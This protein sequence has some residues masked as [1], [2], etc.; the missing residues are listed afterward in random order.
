MSL[1]ARFPLKS[2]NKYQTCNEGS[3][4]MLAN[5]PQPEV[6][7]VEPEE[8][9]QKALNPCVYDLSSMT[10]D[11]SEHSEGK[12]V[13]SNDS[14]RTNGS[15]TSSTDESNFKLSE[16]TQKHTR[17]DHCPLEN[18]PVGAT[19]G[20]AQE[21]SCIGSV[22]KELSD[23]V[24]SQCS[25]VT[26]QICADCSVEQS[27]EKI[28][29]CSESNSEVEELSSAAKYNIFHDRTSFSKL[30]EMASSTTLHEVNSQI[31]KSTENSR[32]ASGQSIGIKHGDASGQSIGIKHGNQIEKLNVTQDSP[33]ASI[34]KCNAYSL[35]MTPN[36][37]VL[38]VG[39]FEIEDPSTDFRKNKD[40]NGIKGPS[41]QAPESET[42]AA[43]ARS[44]S[45][46]SQFH[47]QQQS[48][49]TEQKALPV[50]GE[51]QNPIQ[52]ARESDSGH[53]SNVINE[54][55]KIGSTKSTKSRVHLKEKK[56]TFDWDSLRRQ[57][58]AKAGKREKT[59]NTMDSLDWDAVR[60]ADVGEIADAIKER[61]MNNMLAERIKNFLNLLV[62]KHGAIDLE[63]LRDVP[64]D[65]AKEFLL[66]IR[67]LGLKSVECVRLLTLHNLAFPVDTN[68]GRI[69]VRLGWVP[70]QPLPESLQLHLLE[71]YPVLES[72]QKYLW[73]RLCKL[74]QKTLYELHYQLITFGKV[75]CTKFKP[76]CNACPMRGECRHFASAFASA[77][78]ALP[79]PEQKSIVITKGNNATNPSPSVV[80]NQLP[81]PLPTNTSQAEE[82]QQEEASKRLEARSEINI[83]QPIIEEPASPEPECTQV[84][85]TDIEDAFY[86]ETC[87][88]PTIDVDMEE[89]TLNVQN[90]MEENMELQEGEMS[91]ALVALTPEAACIPTPKLKN[92]NRLR[93]E[94]WVYELPDSHPLLEGWEKRET[95]DPGKYL[96][97]IW[98]P[99]ETA[100]SIQPPEKK[101]SFQDC[102]QLCDEKECFQ[103]NSF[104]ESNSQIVRGTILIPCRTAMRG[105]FP[106]NGTYFQVN[107]VFADDES[108][109]NP[110]S[111]PRSWIWNLRRRTVYFGT[112]VPTIF[113]GLTTQEIQRCFW[114]GYVCVRGF[115]RATRAPRPLKARLHFP[116]SKMEKKK[117]SAPADK[118]EELNLN[119]E[120][121]V[122]QPEMLTNNTNIPNH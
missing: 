118:P 50:L 61:G 77:R 25:V 107:E 115:D 103:C 1:A 59:E 69:A 54:Q 75:F 7:I 79:G 34:I 82:L 101:C 11:T 31:S 39:P 16:S 120:P 56:D 17:D 111:V 67:G 24:S 66:S 116:V 117:P 71:L 33:E 35:K 81:L 4:S 2:S 90:Y 28:G 15:L 83:C 99:G 62:D 80:I 36:G 86:E 119:L 55:T 49:H 9:S 30:L 87:E 95:D 40:E 47:T 106:L 45:M 58:E 97:A 64:P 76:N 112:S 14:C 63:W 92:V 21:N 41:F 23:M 44:Q 110:I 26:S 68:V 72:I 121:N 5:K 78:L 42:Q 13:D 37:G 105:S 19:I 53:K 8:S 46:P 27:P 6:Y 65:Q 73:P 85:E 18:R 93:T 32:D 38:E 89:L 57:A 20:E 113:R 74:D 100:N 84:L 51:T 91:K 104:R 94:H 3:T 114:R 29:S 109:L 122:E 70:L 96:L 98:T 88:I 60:R 43:I 10:L 48:K 102:G 52:K 108:S 22:S 12:A